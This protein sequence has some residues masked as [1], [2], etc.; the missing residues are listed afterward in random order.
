MDLD[1]LFTDDS[2]EALSHRCSI[3]NKEVSTFPRSL[4]ST[5]FC[6]YVVL[7][8]SYVKSLIKFRYFV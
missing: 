3:N 8:T 2:L 7:R 5:M 6:D 4:L 1:I